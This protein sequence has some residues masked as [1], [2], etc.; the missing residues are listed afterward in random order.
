M[1]A[2]RTYS[3]LAFLE[4]ARTNGQTIVEADDFLILL[5]DVLLCY[6]QLMLED[7]YLLD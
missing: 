3:V 4:E 5:A 7:C 6:L 2:R 1:R